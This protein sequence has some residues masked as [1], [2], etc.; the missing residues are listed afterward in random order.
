MITGLGLGITGE[1]IRY[2]RSRDLQQTQASALNNMG[3]QLQVTTN[4]GQSG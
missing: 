3:R 4:W 2:E 1:G